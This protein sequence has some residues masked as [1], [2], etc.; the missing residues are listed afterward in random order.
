MLYPN[1]ACLLLIFFLFSRCLQDKV[2][3]A[4]CLKSLW[5]WLPAHYSSQLESF[6]SSSQAQNLLFLIPSP[7][8]TWIITTSP[9]LAVPQMCPVIITLSILLAAGKLFSLLSATRPPI[10]PLILCVMKVR[11]SMLTIHFLILCCLSMLCSQC[12]HFD[13][14]LPVA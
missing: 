10:A 4:V 12:H 1:N 11:N 5:A 9:S 6:C 2:S 8:L 3:N 13:G 7:G 14:Y